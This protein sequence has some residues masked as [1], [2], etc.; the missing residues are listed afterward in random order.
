MRVRA[1]MRYWI[2]C[3]C[4]LLTTVTAGADVQITENDANNE[5]NVTIVGTITE[6]DS[7]ALQNISDQFAYKSLKVYLDS[8]GGDVA[9]AIK[10]GRI[11]RKNEG[12][13]SI[14][15]SAKCYSSCA[16]I[17]ISGVIRKACKS[18]TALPIAG[19]RSILP[20]DLL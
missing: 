16:L 14:P 18:S 3:A 11:I 19:V 9:A 17:F 13:T 20:S 8:K 15:M 1:S 10:I 5:I 12:E 4:I 2:G 7:N 6:R